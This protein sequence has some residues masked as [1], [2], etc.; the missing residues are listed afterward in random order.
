MYKC[1][2]CESDFNDGVQCTVCLKNIDFACAGITEVGYRKLG[3]ERR[4]NW[5]CNPCKTSSPSPTSSNV[6]LEAIMNE[7]RGMKQQLLCLP[8]LVQDIRSIKEEVSELKIS[9]QFISDKVDDLSQRLKSAEE[10]I[11]ALENN[12]EELATYRNKLSAIETDVVSA[13]RRVR[14]N[15]I[16]IKGVPLKKDED[17]YSVVDKISLAV[18]YSFP[19][20]QINY[21][22]RVPIRNSAEKSI[23]VSFINRYV[24]EE[25]VSAA[26]NRKDL[27]A[28]TIGFSNATMKIFVNDHLTP[29]HKI[30]LTKAKTLARTNNYSFIWV[31]HGK[32]HMRKGT[33]SKVFIINSEKDLNRIA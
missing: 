4:G 18:G 16:E 17:L 33:D 29:E 13:E 21:I 30:L 32:I 11:K 9:S 7:L 5:K 26:R 14:L 27:A 1:A 3:P 8:A 12:Q 24:K 20:S 15:N 22:A 2:L 10:K 6:T 31:K 23:V 28:S 25:F 19:K